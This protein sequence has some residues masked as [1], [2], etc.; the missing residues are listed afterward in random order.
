[1]FTRKLMLLVH[2][3]YDLKN[4]VKYLVRVRVLANAFVKDWVRV[5]IGIRLEG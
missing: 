1:M 4:I 2:T 5:R 3:L